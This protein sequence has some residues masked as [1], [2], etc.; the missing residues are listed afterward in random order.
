M[1]LILAFFLSSF[2]CCQPLVEWSFLPDHGN[3]QSV[4]PDK[5]INFLSK[6]SV[7][8]PCFRRDLNIQYV[9]NFHSDSI[10]SVA[11]FLV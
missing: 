11:S 10:Q 9:P 4:P 6:Y 3:N 8:I 1:K 2:L 7:F 5:E